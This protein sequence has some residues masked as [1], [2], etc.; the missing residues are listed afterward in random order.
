MG[1]ELPGQFRNRAALAGAE[2]ARLEGR[3]LNAELLYEEAIR[4]AHTHGFVHNE[5][6]ATSLPRAFTRRVGSRRSRMP[7][8]A[9]PV[10]AISAGEQMGRCD[11]LI[12]YIRN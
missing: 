1:G 10:P 2:I 12:S 8:C 4:S 6:L 5:A 7:I 3:K 11:N 9:M